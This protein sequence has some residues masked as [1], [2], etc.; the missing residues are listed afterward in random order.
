MRHHGAGYESSSH[1]AIPQAAAFLALLYL[2]QEMAPEPQYE[3]YRVFKLVF[4]FYRRAA[5][6]KNRYRQGKTR[7][8]VQKVGS[9]LSGPWNAIKVHFLTARKLQSYKLSFHSNPFDI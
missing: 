8:R 3:H 4:Y 9:A 5:L 2:R 6:E 7:T 1:L